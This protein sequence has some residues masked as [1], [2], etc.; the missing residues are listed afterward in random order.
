MATGLDWQDAAHRELFERA[1]RLIEAM[2]KNMDKTELISTFKFLD[3]Y[4]KKHFRE[5][6]VAMEK[7]RYSDC[8]THKQA[9]QKFIFTISGLK[10]KLSSMQDTRGIADET[11][12]FLADW[13]YDHIGKTDK[14]LG[15]FLVSA[16]KQCKAV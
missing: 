8:S 6:D 5:E 11:R 9:H 7:H 1:N 15:T 3:D 14:K 2:E 13:L 12:K 4:I 10:G 16:E